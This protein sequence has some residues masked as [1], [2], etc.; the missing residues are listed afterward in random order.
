[1]AD[2]YERAQSI[3]FNLYTCIG[4]WGVKTKN[5]CYR[6]LYYSYSYFA[7]FLATLYF[8]LQ[9]LDVKDSLDSMATLSDN[10]SA[11]I[12]S[13]LS[14]TKVYVL[15]FRLERVERL[16]KHFRE[17]LN[18]PGV[19]T[20]EEDKQI[21]KEEAESYMRTSKMMYVFVSVTISS[22][23]IGPAFQGKVPVRMWTPF[24]KYMN[25]EAY[26]SVYFYQC[27]LL[28]IYGGIVMSIDLII[29]LF[30]FLV[31]THF[32]ILEKNIMKFGSGSPEERRREFRNI[33]IH[34]QK[35]LRVHSEVDSLFSI[36][37]F[38]HLISVGVLISVTELD[39]VQ[40]STNAMSMRFMRQIGNLTTAI[41]DMFLYSHYGTLLEEMSMRIGK[42]IYNG[43]WLSF[44][45]A[46]RRDF[47]FVIIRSQKKCK[48]TAGKMLP[49]NLESY[50]RILST[51]YNLMAVL[52]Q[53][54]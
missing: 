35:I 50:L 44:T 36:S 20:S 21:F 7:V 51:S 37:I 31:S 26:V 5:R 34:H 13:V 3:N 28:G 25:F 12:T 49:V 6:F 22:W 15:K 54:K 41:F 27:L 23:W 52:K 4:F 24:D 10:L 38:I 17:H 46:E 53:T 16:R 8:V 40:T 29:W 42:A 9:V 1:M 39:L 14:I 30:I 33:V 11:T 48:I 47:M 18:A 32:K 2:I 19:G 43:P 45:P